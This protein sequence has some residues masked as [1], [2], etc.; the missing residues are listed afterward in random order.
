MVKKKNIKARLRMWG[1]FLEE[2]EANQDF[3]NRV[4]FTDA[5]HLLLHGR[6]N[7]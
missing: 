6:W 4:W 7:A 2:F 1:G 3:T 5:S